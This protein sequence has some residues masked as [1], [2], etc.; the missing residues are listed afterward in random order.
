LFGFGKAPFVPGQTNGV[1]S[2]LI[3]VVAVDVDF[4]VE[5]VDSVDGCS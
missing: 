4:A 2:V 3:I 1:D 5:S